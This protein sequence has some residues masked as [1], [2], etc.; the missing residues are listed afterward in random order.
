MSIETAPF[1]AA[2]YLTDDETIE[3]YLT[4]AMED[5]DPEI[6]PCRNEFFRCHCPA[7]IY[8]RSISP[9]LRP[10]HA[11]P[12]RRAPRHTGSATDRQRP[13]RSGRTPPGSAR[14]YARP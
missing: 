13:Y 2:D 5:P 11:I 7:S 4:V 10:R 6:F 9:P 12:V 3:A 1:D 8:R 14:R